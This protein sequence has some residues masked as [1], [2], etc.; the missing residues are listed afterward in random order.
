MIALAQN[1]YYRLSE[2]KL[3]IKHGIQRDILEDV[4]FTAPFKIT[5]PFYDSENNMKIMTLSISA[6]IMEGDNQEIEIEVGKDA[7]AEI[8][9]QSFEKIHRMKTGSANRRTALTVREGGLLIYN[10]L[11]TIPFADSAFKTDTDIYLT[12][13]TS[14][15][16]YSEVISCGRVGMDEKFQYRFYKALTKVFQGG[17]PIYFDNAQFLPSKFNLQG[18]C[19]FEGYTHLSN[20]ILVNFSDNESLMSV[21]REYINDS[22]EITGGCSVNDNLL[23]VRMLANSAEDLTRLHDKITGFVLERTPR[24]QSLVAND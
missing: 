8:T 11:P 9:S 4:K 22:K 20:M 10:P 1:Q 16:I 6:G 19:M 23:C 17:E 14:K 5:K 13:S 7:R 18:F 12:D 21:I 2:L 3:K 15:L 24:E